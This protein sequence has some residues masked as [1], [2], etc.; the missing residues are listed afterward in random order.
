[1]FYY[2]RFYSSETSIESDVNMS[3]HLENYNEEL[4]PSRWLEAHCD[5]SADLT[6]FPK[7]LVLSDISG[8]GE[9]RLVLVD[10]KFGEG[11]Y[12]RLKVYKGTVLVSDQALPD[13]PSALISFY[14][15][16]IEPRVP[17]VGLACGSDLLIYKNNKPFYKFSLPSLPISA[18]EEDVWQRL[19]QDPQ[20]SYRTIIKDLESVPFVSLSARSQTLLTLPPSEADEFIN[21]YKNTELSKESTITCMT[22]L[23]RNSEEPHSISYP[24]LATEHGQIFIVDS[25][26]FTI[27]HEARITNTKAIPSIVLAAGKFEVEFRILVACRERYVSLLRKDWL[28]GK[29]ILQT[30]SAIVD[31]ALM[32]GDKFICIATADKM[33]NCYSKRG[34]KLWSVKMMQPI[35]CICL[36]TLQHLSV[37]L[38]AVGMHG[39]VIQLYNSRHLVDY[40]STSDTPS[41]IVFGHLG[42]EEHVMVI[43]TIGGTINFKILKR[44]ADF[45]INQD[46]GILPTTQSKPLPLPKRSKL[47][48]EQSLRERHNAIEM[49]QSFQQDL[50]RLRLTAARTL[51]QINCDQSGIG[52]P[53]EQIKLSAQV[54]GLGPLFTLILTLENMNSDKALIQLSA[55]FHCNPDIYKLSLYMLPIPLVPPGLSYKIENKVT[56]CLHNEL[57]EDATES[58]SNII[59]VFIVRN[60]QVQPVLAATINMPPTDPLGYTV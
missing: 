9:Y 4:N 3:Q 40:I 55:V 19:H 23:Y 45:G 43:S 47:F 15:D 6:I 52:N 27:I 5:R 53:K 42:Q 24:V 14:V 59:R 17:V 22:T 8:D 11:V 49:H 30:T 38:I 39:G 57:T 18:L 37:S 25:Q 13:V 32:P 2:I 1:M 51:L 48:L 41:A 28:E 16:T 50:V 33:L 21:K 44:T 60:D 29:N 46:T 35:T 36:V 26:T 56:D 58:A 31:M 54:L 12:A 34:N 7:N 10:V 20:E